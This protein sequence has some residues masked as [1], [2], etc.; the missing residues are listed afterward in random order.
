VLRRP[1]N[2]MNDEMD[3]TP[4]YPP[5]TTAD[6]KAMDMWRKRKNATAIKLEEAEQ[7]LARQ[8][9]QQMTGKGKK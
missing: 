1:E 9:A 4:V 7:E 2:F 3:G 6:A 8:R 5:G